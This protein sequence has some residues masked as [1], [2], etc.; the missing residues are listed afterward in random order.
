MGRGMY[1][2]KTIKPPIPMSERLGPSPLFRVRVTHPLL[3]IRAN[4]SINAKINAVITNFGE[5][6]ITEVQNGFGKI[7]DDNWIMLKYTEE[8]K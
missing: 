1:K 6:N 4:P 8:I 5:Y 7:G 3:N 2:R